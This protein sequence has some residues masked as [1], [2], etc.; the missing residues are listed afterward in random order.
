MTRT[1]KLQIE[2][3]YQRNKQTKKKNLFKEI[4]TKHQGKGKDNKTTKK[5]KK[6]NGKKCVS[7]TKLRLL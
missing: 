6:Q 3:T 5:K 4:V 2:T 7:W 1:D